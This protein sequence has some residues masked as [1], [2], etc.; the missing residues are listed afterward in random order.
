MKREFRAGNFRVP[1]ILSS[2]VRRVIVLLTSGAS[3]LELTKAKNAP[4]VG[5]TAPA[6]N[7][8]VRAPNKLRNW[9]SFRFE[10][11]LVA[12]STA[13]FHSAFAAGPYLNKPGGCSL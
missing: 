12:C 4:L 3:L 9:M 11:F 13:P 1:K 5:L 10:S 8:P 7:L 6:L 2:D